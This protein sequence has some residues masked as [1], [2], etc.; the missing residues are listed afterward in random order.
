M[1]R[2]DILAK[3]L[4]EVVSVLPLSSWWQKLEIKEFAVVSELKRVQRPGLFSVCKFGLSLIAKL[5]LNLGNNGNKAHDLCDH[6][7]FLVKLSHNILLITS[8][9]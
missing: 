8:K 1:L 5:T 7:S 9:P 2:N 3:T 6:H 4:R